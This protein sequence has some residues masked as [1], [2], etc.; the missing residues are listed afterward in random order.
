MIKAII[1]DIDGVLLD[2]QKA[3]GA[4]F[5]NVLGDSG[6]K[7]PEKRQAYKVFNRTL[8][9]GLRILSK[10]KSKSKLKKLW[11]KARSFP[12]PLNLARIPKGEISAIEKLSGSYKLGI[13]TSRVR[14]GVV[15]LRAIGLPYDKFGVVVTFEDYKHPKPHPEPLLLTA[16][17]LGVKPCNCIYVGDQHTDMQAAHAAGMRFILYSKKRLKGADMAVST[18]PG[19]L[20]SIKALSN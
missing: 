17:K 14:T 15:K 3:N 18:F 11:L 6:Y 9:D 7:R 12:Y 16:K 8:M 4:F 13:A 5:Q 1:F 20:A 10:E 19:L 2:S